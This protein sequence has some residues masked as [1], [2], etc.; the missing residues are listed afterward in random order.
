M[1]L[2]R[3]Q[4]LTQGMKDIKDSKK[5]EGDS[6]S[7]DDA[8]VLNYLGVSFYNVRDY[9]KAFDAFLQ[10]AE[11]NC[12]PAMVNLG[13]CYFDGEG[14]AQNIHEGLKWIRKAANLGNTKAM[15]YLASGY[16]LGKFDLEE[17]HAL[18]FSWCKKAAENGDP[19][20]MY[21]VANMYLNGDGVREDFELGMKWLI[22]AAD[23]GDV[24]AMTEL[25]AILE[26]SNDIDLKKLAVE[27]YLG[28]VQQGNLIAI[29]NLGCILYDGLPGII[30][31]DINR[32]KDLFE[33]AANLGHVSSMVNLAEALGHMGDNDGYRYWYRKAAQ[34]GNEK[35]QAVVQSW[36]EDSGGCFITTS[37]CQNFGKPD[38]CYELTAFR[39]FRDGWLMNQSDGKNLIAEYYSIAPKIVDKI[40]MRTNAAKIYCDIWENYLK[41]CLNFIENGN[42]IQCK[43][44]Y[45]EMVIYLKNFL[46]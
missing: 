9:Y 26:E 27:Y 14:T 3:M 7:K 10:A 18:S 33:K 32:A 23:A 15:L 44:K 1:D 37:V 36:E 35:A 40:N 31:A 34:C 20:G 39:N 41:P 19:I 29:N 46:L 24:D 42:Y 13:E 28:A 5:I 17:N 16:Y 45:I 2:Q 6:S 30:S 12:V 11:K 21:Q 43:S 8:D 22:K 38:D 25:A 4:A